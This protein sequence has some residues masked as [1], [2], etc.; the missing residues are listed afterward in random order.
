MKLP[1]NELTKT[2]HPSSDSS[3]YSYHSCTSTSSHD[4]YNTDSEEDNSLNYSTCPD[5]ASLKE[6]FEFLST[7]S[8]EL[9]NENSDVIIPLTDVPELPDLLVKAEPFEQVM[10]PRNHSCPSFGGTAFSFFAA[11]YGSDPTPAPRCSDTPI[12][13][14]KGC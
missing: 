14:K 3:S 4:G 8:S 11:R 12:L 1:Q 9:I 2:D 13:R 5:Y 7:I 6:E 10:L